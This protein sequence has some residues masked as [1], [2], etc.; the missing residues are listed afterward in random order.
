M[1]DENLRTLTRRMHDL[2]LELADKKDRVKAMER[3][4]AKAQTDLDSM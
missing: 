3:A 2:E 1:L 4:N